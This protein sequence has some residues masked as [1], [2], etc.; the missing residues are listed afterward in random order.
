MFCFKNWLTLSSAL[1]GEN[2]HTADLGAAPEVHHEHRLVHIVVVHDGAVGQV[3]VLLPVHGQR[4]VPVLP[5]LP[6]VALV[7]HPGLAKVRLVRNWNREWLKPKIATT[8][9]PDS[10][11]PA[12][13]LTLRKPG[14]QSPEWGQPITPALRPIL[15]LQV[16]GWIRR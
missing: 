8:W 12:L 13:W 11:H 14:P 15:F 7:V 3:G 5:L 4:A 9:C 10:P 6:C 16:S 2:D 1:P